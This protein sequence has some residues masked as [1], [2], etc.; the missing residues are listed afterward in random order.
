MVMDGDWRMLSG[1]PDKKKTEGNRNEKKEQR[2]KLPPG[3][4]S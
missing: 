3:R 4:L 2:A 1:P